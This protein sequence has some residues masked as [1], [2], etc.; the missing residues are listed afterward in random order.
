MF[1]GLKFPQGDTQGH[2]L[3]TFKFKFFQDPGI[4]KGN[5][6]ILADS[7][8][9]TLMVILL[10]PATFVEQMAGSNR[11]AWIYMSNDSSM[12]G[13]FFFSILA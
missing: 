8:S 10:I 9:K 12:M 1:T 13:I 11:L 3:F 5:F 7:F 2:T 4:S 6:P